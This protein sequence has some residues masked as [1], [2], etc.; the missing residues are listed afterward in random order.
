M[1]LRS[2]TGELWQARIVL[3][4]FAVAGSFVG[5]LLAFHVGLLPPKLEARRYEVM[6]ATVMALIDTPRSQTIDLSGSSGA[7]VGI[8]ADRA[9]LLASLVTQAPLTR[10]I[11][12]QAGVPARLLVGVPEKRLGRPID[13]GPKVL[14]AAVSADDKRAYVLHAK[15]PLVPEGATPIIEIQAQAPDRAGASRLANAT[16]IALRARVRDVAAAQAVPPSRAITVTQLSSPR[17]AAVAHGFGPIAV[18]VA[19]VFFLMLGCGG[20]LFASLL[21]SNWRRSGELARGQR[22][23]PQQAGR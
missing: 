22:S 1:R 17:L 23:W 19:T 11:A 14:G 2:I 12:A 6:T 4:L 16:V 7:D 21:R 13:E 18:G 5:I 20:V 15:V 3:S 9:N 8:L 10:E